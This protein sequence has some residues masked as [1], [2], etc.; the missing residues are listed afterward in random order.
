MRNAVGRRQVFATAALGGTA[1][2]APAPAGA[3]QNASPIVGAWRLTGITRTDLD[4]NAISKFYGEHP[5]GM[6]TYTPAG[7]MVVFLAGEGRR[8]PAGPAPTEAE[9][10]ELFGTIVAYAGTYR[11]EG[12]KVIHRVETAWT[13]ALNG[14]ELVRAFAVEGDRLTIRTVAARNM[15]TGRMFVDALAFTRVE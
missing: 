1:L 12:D 11:V 4:T 10:A 5:S 3:A 14:T 15:L 6:I 8:A 9:R 2:A 7:H 13:P